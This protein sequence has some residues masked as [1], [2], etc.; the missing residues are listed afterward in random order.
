[1]GILLF[2]ISEDDCVD[3]TFNDQSGEISVSDELP[4]KKS[5]G[6][7]SILGKCLDATSRIPLNHEE[8]VTQELKQYL[9]HSKLD[10]ED[11]PL[12]WWN[13]EETRYPHLAILAR[14]F[15]CVCVCATS[16]PSERVFSCGGKI[17]TDRRTALKPDRVDQLIFLALNVL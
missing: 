14:K 15:L 7:N 3:D 1:M 9:S 11:S 4:A 6:L 16:V 12:L 17:V 5:K 10:M 13:V 8:K 2:Q